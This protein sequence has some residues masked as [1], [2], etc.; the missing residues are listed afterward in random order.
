MPKL[1]NIITYINGQIANTLNTER[2]QGAEYYNDLVELVPIIES[3]VRR[4]YPAIIDHYGE[5]TSAVIDDTL[6]LQVYHRLLSVEYTTVPE[7][8]YGEQGEV[9]HEQANMKMVVISDRNKILLH[10]TDLLASIIANIPY[11]MPSSLL[12]SYNLINVIIEFQSAITNM[13]EVFRDEY[14]IEQL[15]LKPNSIMYAVNYTIKTTFSKVC[16][17][18]CD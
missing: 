4:T 2:F 1:K 17:L 16:F 18:N 12:S 15:E 14:A 8:S 9:I 6:P 3:D 5:G 11:T 13:E 10:G 7:D